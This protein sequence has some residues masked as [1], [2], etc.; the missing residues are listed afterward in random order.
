[1]YLKEKPFS[2]K[3]FVVE[4]GFSTIVEMGLGESSFKTW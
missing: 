3:V 4:K 2:G 1:M